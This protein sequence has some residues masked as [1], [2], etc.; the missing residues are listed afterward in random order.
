[1]LGVPAALGEGW[2]PAASFRL[3]PACFRPV[4]D[5]L[6]LPSSYT[7]LPAPTPPHPTHTHAHL[8]PQVAQRFSLDVREGDILVVATDG[9]FDNVY[10]DEAAALVSATKVSGGWVTGMGGRVGRRVGVRLAGWLAVCV[11]CLCCRLGRKRG[12]LMGRADMADG[13]LIWFAVVHV[14]PGQD[15]PV[16]HACVCLIH[17]TIACLPEYLHSGNHLAPLMSPPLRACRSA[18]RVRRPP[19]PRLPSLRACGRQTPPTSPPL[20]TERSSWGIATL[21][22]KWTT[23]QSSVHM[24]LPPA[25]GRPWRR[26]RRQR[27]QPASCEPGAQLIDQRMHTPRPRR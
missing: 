12:D 21:E 25:R 5:L 1:M 20:P 17:L 15:C 14:W 16:Q 13:W 2:I 6:H 8:H 10:P 27:R 24:W 26:L 23:S 9:L 3:P 19:P 7:A 18:V 11:A 4:P 22:A